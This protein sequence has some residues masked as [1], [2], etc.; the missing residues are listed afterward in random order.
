[1]KKKGPLAGKFAGLCFMAYRP[2]IDGPVMH[3]MKREPS[4][5]GFFIRTSS[6]LNAT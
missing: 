4:S 2:Q 5:G 6:L 1:M 3:R